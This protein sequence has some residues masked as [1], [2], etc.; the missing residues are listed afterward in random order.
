[1]SS[2]PEIGIWDPHMHTLRSDGGN[3]TH[4]MIA[5]HA[6][7][8]PENC[9]PI[10]S[11]TDHNTPPESDFLELCQQHHVIGVPAAEL[12]FIMTE[13][14]DTRDARVSPEVHKQG[15][16]MKIAALWTIM[17]YFGDEQQQ[18]RTE[19][20]RDLLEKMDQRNCKERNSGNCVSLIDLVLDLHQIDEEEFWQNYPW[21]ERKE[22]QELISILRGAVQSEFKRDQQIAEKKYPLRKLRAEILT[23]WS[24]DI[25]ERASKAISDIYEMEWPDSAPSLRQLMEL[26]QDKLGKDFGKFVFILAHPK[27]VMNTRLGTFMQWLEA[28]KK[29]TLTIW[30]TCEISEPELA[31]LFAGVEGINGANILPVQESVYDKVH[32]RTDIWVPYQQMGLAFRA[33]SDAHTFEMVDTA[34]EVVPLEDW[35]AE[36]SLATVSKGEVYPMW[37]L[38]TVKWPIIGPYTPFGFWVWLFPYESYNLSASEMPAKIAQKGLIYSRD[39]LQLGSKVRGKIKIIDEETARRHLVLA[40]AGAII[41]KRNR[42]D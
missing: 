20:F 34:Y 29:D 7:K 18:R 37:G 26:L 17:A 9:I 15:V 13:G 21:I 12:E 42:R 10:I 6:A 3:T 41:R 27:S 11:I 36:A 28:I 22:F 35:S 14:R 5:A 19:K 38:E 40:K 39:R 32:G 8:V 30:D 4:E 33:G 1:M 16:A 31:K 24:P 2:L 25:F 23:Y